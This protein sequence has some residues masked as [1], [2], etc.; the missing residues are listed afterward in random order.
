MPGSRDHRSRAAERLGRLAPV[1]CRWVER[2]LLSSTPPLTPAQFLALDAIAERPI[3]AAELARRAAV[4]PAAVSQLVAGLVGA[5]LVERRSEEPDR[6]REPLALT[7][8]GSAALTSARAG[9]RAALA[10][11][12]GELPLPEAEALARALARLDAALTG[13][14][15]PSRPPRPRHPP[16]PP[17]PGR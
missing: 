11:V 17:G 5:G 9:V 12:L 2:A 8:R 7:G 10:E 13:K 14:P 3:V 4:T 16:G 15:P 1:V 6:R